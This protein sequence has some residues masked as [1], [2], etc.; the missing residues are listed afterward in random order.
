MKKKYIYILIGIITTALI[1]LVAIQIY[2][3]DNA[4]KLREEDFNRNVR[5]ALF[6]V[7]DK[8]EKIDAINRIKAHKNGHQLF[9]QKIIML[10]R[11]I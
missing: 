9:N 10:R 8:L 7:T 1:G 5:S 11:G 4:V 2:W 6:T 3:I